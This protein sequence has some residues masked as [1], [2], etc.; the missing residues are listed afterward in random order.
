MATA[1]HVGPLPG[2]DDKFTLTPKHFIKRVCREMHILNFRITLFP[3]LS[4]C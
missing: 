1:K 2:Y 4:Y 3:V